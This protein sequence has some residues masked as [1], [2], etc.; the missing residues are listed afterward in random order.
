MPLGLAQL[1]AQL[2]QAVKY[3]LRAGQQP[4][5]RLREREP[6]C[7][8]LEE[9]EAQVFLKGLQPRG[10]RG[11]RQAQLLREPLEAAAARRPGKFRQPVKVHMPSLRNLA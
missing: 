4:L 5:A 2:A 11:L 3:L 9:L 7:A 8:A 10:Q 1:A 6:S